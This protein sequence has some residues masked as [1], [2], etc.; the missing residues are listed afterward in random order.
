MVAI[1]GGNDTLR[2]K[3][4]EGEMSS[5]KAAHLFGADCQIRTDDLP[6]TRRVHY[7]FAKSAKYSKPLL[8]QLSYKG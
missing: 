7:H 3:A 6:L 2:A 4:S 1:F 5:L 8:Y